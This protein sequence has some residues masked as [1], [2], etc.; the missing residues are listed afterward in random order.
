LAEEI[1]QEAFVRAYEKISTFSG[2]ARFRT[3]LVQIGINLVRDRRRTAGRGPKVV[4]LDELRERGAPASEPADE[5]LL[6]EPLGSISRKE[7]LARLEQEIERLPQDYR[8]AFVLKHI[9][10]LSY[11]EMAEVTGSSVG[12]LKVRVHRARVWLRRALLSEPDREVS[13]GR[14]ARSLP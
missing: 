7:A 1:A 5:R 9:E 11:S 10:N 4:S 14:L 2:R 3:W 6:D 12:S 8:E 13:H